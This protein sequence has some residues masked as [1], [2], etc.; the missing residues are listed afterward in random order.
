MSVFKFLYDTH[1]DSEDYV[2]KC[3]EEASSPA[4]SLDYPDFK[5]E[6]DKKWE[7]KTISKEKGRGLV[8]TSSIFPGDVIIVESKMFGIKNQ[9]E[10]H[11]DE[12]DHE[13]HVEGNVHV[14]ED[15]KSDSEDDFSIKC[16]SLCMKIIGLSELNISQCA[17]GEIY[18]SEACRMKAFGLHHQ[19]LCPLIAGEE[20]DDFI[21]HAESTNETFKVLA[22]IY[23]FL[24]QRAN[25]NGGDLFRSLY[26]FKYFTKGIWWEIVN[27]PSD[28]KDFEKKDFIKD[29]QD[30]LFD[31][32]ELLKKVFS[33]YIVKYSDLFDFRVYGT[34]MGMLEMN[35]ISVVSRREEEEVVQLAEGIALYSIISL[36]NHSCIPN[37]ALLKYPGCNDDS[38]AVFCIREIAPGEEILISYIDEEA[39]LSIRTEELLDYH[40]TCACE[41]CRK[42]VTTSA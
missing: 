5:I 1:S 9:S 28:L 3:I 17:C 4:A 21:D 36:L 18:C 19:L 35:A 7:I 41:A 42:D 10:N 31:S 33:N 26:R 27:P 38:T 20:I 34:F 22:Q 16:C 32:F 30:L 11:S 14:D 39:P 24:I 12:A 2:S 37:A 23:A 8:S 40:F 13:D 15:V 6:F 25:E 29:L